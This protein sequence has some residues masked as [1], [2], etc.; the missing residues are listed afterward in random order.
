MLRRAF[1]ASALVLALAA[2]G[3]QA[4]QSEG[5]LK[6]GATAVPHA[7]IL[8]QVK[9][10]LAAEGIDL[11]IIVFNDYV[12]P[13]TQLAEKRLDA[14]YFQTKPYLDEFNAGRG[15]SLVTVAGV[16]V[17]PLGAYSR[18]YKALAALPNGAEIAL[19][20][21]ASNTG[22]SLLLLQTAGLITLKKAADPVQTVADIAG[23]PRGFR[24]RELEAAT[25]PRVLDQVDLAVI[26]T[27]YALDARLN[28][29]SDA[30]ALEGG[31]SPYVNYLVTRADNRDDPRI[32]ALAAALTSQTIKDY[33]SRTYGGAVVPA[34]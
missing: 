16:H 26:N 31:D 17:E 6:V 25:L 13:N 34:R 11:Q 8:E 32:R 5:S 9:P 24:F 20:N 10:I 3:R 29:R 2:C 15:T 28:P 14:N 33:I 21:D 19:P 23:N 7:E 18:K 12:Q 4:Q 27:N 30:L 1:L 22:R